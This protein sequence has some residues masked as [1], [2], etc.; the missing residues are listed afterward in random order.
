MDVETPGFGH[1]RPVPIDLATV[2]QP[3]A[4]RAQLE[5]EH[6][7]LLQR[8]ASL[9]AG[10]DR[11]MA[12]V[13]ELGIV[14]DDML[15][16][17]ADFAA[18]IKASMKRIETAR[19]GAKE[20][21]N[22]AGKVVQAFFKGA[23]LDKLDACA[24]G[25]NAKQTVYL[26]A[27]AAKERAAREAE[28]IRLEREAAEALKAAEAA[29]TAERVEEAVVLEDKAAAATE[30]AKAKPADLVRH[31]SDLGVTST[32]R[33]TLVFDVTD[34]AKVPLHLMQV[35]DAAVLAQ[36]RIAKDPVAEQPVP[37]ISF[38]WNSKAV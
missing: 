17:A 24:K 18:Q 38:R 16:K 4:L 36:G 33:R 5:A 29:P 27:K 21:I 32:L 8:T 15:G 3:D 37:G 22:E 20:P 9:M 25:I 34:K 7:D 30:A 28:R 14:D 10:Y 12:Q 1:N 13:G 11:F 35:V 23:M 26:Q 6:A 19:E 31:R 2:L